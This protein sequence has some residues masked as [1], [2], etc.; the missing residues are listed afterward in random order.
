MDQSEIANKIN[1]INSMTKY[2][3]IKTYH[4]MA[5]K[6]KLTNEVQVP[7][8]KPAILTEK[9]DGTNARI[10]VFSDGFYII[11]SRDELLYAKGDLIVNPQLGIVSTLKPI[12]EKIEPLPQMFG[13]VMVYY[14]EVF[15]GNIS[16]ASKQ[17]TGN[18]KFGAR[19]FDIAYIEDRENIC[20][21]PIEKIANW[22]NNGGQNFFSE[23]S[24][25][26][27]AR[28]LNLEVTPRINVSYPI[29]TDIKET[30]DWLK[31]QIKVSNVVLDNSAIGKPEG[32]VI[33]TE[34][35]SRIAKLRF[36]EYER[37]FR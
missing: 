16:K 9:V 5:E 7:F 21:L 3:S 36:D 32:I 24:L 35:R 23:D 30:F 18:E 20:S 10:I 25:T 14:F 8:D 37:T 22:R 1:E 6:G 4:R 27:H 2:P 19:L 29:P 28:T 26:F 33:R 15:G 12:A 31:S 13:C 11:G 34:D 17:Y